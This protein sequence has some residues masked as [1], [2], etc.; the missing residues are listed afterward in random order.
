MYNYVGCAWRQRD[1]AARPVEAIPWDEVPL[2]SFWSPVI[3]CVLY[4]TGARGGWRRCGAPY[5]SAVA[6]AQWCMGS[7]A[8]SV[9]ASRCTSG[10]R[11]LTTRCAQ[12]TRCALL[13]GLHAAQLR[14]RLPCQLVLHNAFLCLASV[15]MF[16]GSAASV[17]EVYLQRGFW[18]CWA[19]PQVCAAWHTLRRTLALLT[20]TAALSAVEAAGRQG[21][22]LVL[23]VLCEQVLRAAGHRVLGGQE[24]ASAHGAGAAAR[25]SRATR[26]A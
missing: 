11:G 16:Y 18:A 15:V 19:D 24:A 6:F 13:F 10:S 22:F 26:P 3:G 21:S 7:S 17:L 23:R 2:S 25:A 9:I 14:A 8:C 20:V 5:L 12:R 4:L 1:A